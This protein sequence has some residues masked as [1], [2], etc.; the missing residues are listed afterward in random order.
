MRSFQGYGTAGPD[1][2]CCRS[3]RYRTEIVRQAIDLA[4]PLVVR[5]VNA[6]DDTKRI[7]FLERFGLPLQMHPYEA[8]TFVLGEQREARRLLEQA[9]SGDATSAIKAANAALKRAHGAD[10]FSLEHGRTVLTVTDPMSFM[11]QEIAMVAANGAQ[12]ATCE[13]CGDVFLTGK[14]T[15]RRITSRFCRDLCRVS[16]HRANKG[17]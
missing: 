14:L 16:A 12:L 15:K 17:G 11:F 4:D 8:H 6:T 10:R 9:G 1:W 7:A 2:F 3:E 5:F 13:R